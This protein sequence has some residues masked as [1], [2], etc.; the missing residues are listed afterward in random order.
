[1]FQNVKRSDVVANDVNEEI[2]ILQR[3]CGWFTKRFG[4]KGGSP[5][6]ESSNKR[7]QK[8]LRLIN[9]QSQAT[10][11]I[12]FANAVVQL[13][14]KTGYASLL[15]TQFPQ[16]IVGKPLGSFKGCRAL[17][18][19]YMEESNRERSAAL[20]R[21]LVAQQSGKQLLADGTQQ[22]SE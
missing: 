6:G 5:G 19:L 2:P 18:N 17:H 20:L 10:R 14:R 22:D 11:N 3:K 12:C 7:I 15:M 16:F 9:N 13:F 21:K 4:L 8:S 1:M